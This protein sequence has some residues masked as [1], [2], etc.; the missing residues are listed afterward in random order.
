MNQ[1]PK[2]NREAR[3]QQLIGRKI[4]ELRK[5]ERI[6]STKLSGLV[7]ISQ[8]QLSKI[9]NGKIT[10][11]IKTL[12]KLCQAFNRPLSYLFQEEDEL[13]HVLGTLNISNGPEKEGFKYFAEK[14][15]ET[16]RSRITLV[17]LE[18]QQ[19][20]VASSQAES[21]QKGIIDLFIEDM[22]HLKRFVPETNIFSLPYAFD[23]IDHQLKFLNGDFFK[24]NI[25]QPLKQRGIRLINP[26]WNWQRALERKIGPYQRS[27]DDRGNS[28][29]TGLAGS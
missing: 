6:S 24:T 8:G 4:R 5:S 22:D 15:K 18:A 21:L 20:G 2:G 3:I 11:S 9:E 7:G 28:I 1:I 12:S 29:Q 26:S 17:V 14:V 19:V 25:Q 10:I 23:G 16:T 27:I 13:P